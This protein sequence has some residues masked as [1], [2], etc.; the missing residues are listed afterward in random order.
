MTVVNV[1]ARLYFV[2]DLDVVKLTAQNSFLVTLNY[3]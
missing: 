3:N 2:E 1:G